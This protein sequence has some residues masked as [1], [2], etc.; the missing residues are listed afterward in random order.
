MNK[1]GDG[2][3]KLDDW[4]IIANI[5]MSILTFATAIISFMTLHEM[6]KSRE[7]NSKPYVIVGYELDDKMFFRLYIKNI[8]ASPARNITVKMSEPIK[9]K[10]DFNKDVRDVIFK[11]TIKY[12]A[13]NQKIDTIAFPIWSIPKANGENAE[14]TV[15]IKYW[16]SNLKEPY[17]ESYNIDIA[18]QK[19]IFYLKNKNFTDLVQVLEK[20]EKK[21]K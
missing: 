20:I 18:S 21:I 9:M 13:P 15:I 19:N 16:S 7:E 5:V 17:E 2:D 1:E 12:L 8:G 10:D 3:V 11:D 4:G 6:K 14:N